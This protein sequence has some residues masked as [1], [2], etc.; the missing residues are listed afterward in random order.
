MRS[1]ARSAD[2]SVST[3]SRVL[4]GSAP[5]RPA[6]RR[7]VLRAAR[8][9]AYRPNTLARG[10]RRGRSSTVALLVPDITNPFFA[11]IAKSVED[12]C[13]RRQYS[14]ILCN[15]ENDIDRE[16]RYLELM[17]EHRVDGLILVPARDRSLLRTAWAAPGRHALLLDRGVD[18]A[19]HDCVRTDNE[20]GMLLAVRHLV[21]L[22]HRRIGFIAGPARVSTADE[23]LAGF[24]RA[25]RLMELD[26]DPAIVRRGGFSFDTGLRVMRAFLRLPVPP[27]AVVASSDVMAL[28]AVR[29]V[30][31]AGGTV[32]ATMSIVG[33]DGIA[34]ARLVQPPLTTVVQPMRELGERAVETLLAR[35][36]G[37]R[38]GPV[39]VRLKPR[40]A[41]Q[42]STTRPGQ[43]A[44]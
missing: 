32:P 24:R 4:T 6:K 5:V 21:D 42:Q 26:P 20:M 11:E 34:A 2:V 7:R 25:Q 37:R 22:G 8:Q 17:A 1:V 35:V 12:H 18:S 28:G 16:R 27:T 30:Y 43:A 14:L 10:L 13:A 40:L 36:N 33:F 44:R 29:A 41:V 31:E 38:G 39:R 9:L 3:V 23:R 19:R 15:T